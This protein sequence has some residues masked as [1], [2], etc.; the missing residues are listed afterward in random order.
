MYNARTGAIRKGAKPISK[1]DWLKLS[2]DEMDKYVA[3]ED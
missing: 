1:S 3:L 2:P